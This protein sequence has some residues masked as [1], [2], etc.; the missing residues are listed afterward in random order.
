LNA[1]LVFLEQASP[2]SIVIAAT[3][4]R[5]ILDR[6][7]FRRFDLVITYHLPSAPEAT[8]VM[9]SR[10]GPIAK[11]LRWR[12]LEDA[13][14]GLSHAELVKASEAAAKRALMRGDEHV[15]APDVLA[16]LT[17]RQAGSVA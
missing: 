10:L 3:N 1:F 16:A 7:L 11:G 17:D 8:K 2:E 4:H 9:R 5:Q 15:R 14:V 6:A 12:S 13:T